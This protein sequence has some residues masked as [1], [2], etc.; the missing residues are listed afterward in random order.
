MP[1]CI[2]A[3]LSENTPTAAKAVLEQVGEDL[4]AQQAALLAAGLLKI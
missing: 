2:I 4:P 3:H 1:F